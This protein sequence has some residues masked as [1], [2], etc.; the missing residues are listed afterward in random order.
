VEHLLSRLESS[1]RP[2]RILVSSA[3]EA[4]TFERLAGRSTAIAE[5]IGALGLKTL[6]LHMDNR[7]DWVV[8]D[9]A[10][11]QAAVCLVPLPTF[12]S[13]GQIR[14]VLDSVPVDAVFTEQPE[15]LATLCAGRIR[16]G[17]ELAIGG[18]ELLLLDPASQGAALPPGSGKVTFTSGSTGRPKGVCLS[19]AQL[20]TQAAALS[21][22]AG[23]AAPRHL[24]LLPL[25]TLLENIAGIYAPLLAGGEVVVPTLDEVG[26]TGSSSLNPRVLLALLSREQP[27]SIILT[28]QLLQLLV[29]AAQ[30]GWVPPPSL[31]FVAVGGAKVSPDL[32]DAARAAGI[33]AFEGYGLSE[34]ASVVSLNVPGSE[35][36]GS[37]GRPLAHLG[38]AIDAGEIVVRG[39]AMLG[40][41]GEPASWHPN[42][43]RTGDLGYFD[44]DGYLFINGRSKNLLISSYGRNISP[45]WVES[46][47]QAEPSLA[48]CVVFGDAR[49]YCVALL[50][51]RDPSASDAA[52]QRAVDRC[53]ARLPDYARVRH[54]HRLAQP[55][56]TAGGLLTENGRPK[57][58][59][60][61]SR[62]DAVIESLYEPPTNAR[63]A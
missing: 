21:R 13:S 41:A 5:L 59:A 4:L 34:C 35:R 28:P 30:S 60:I 46:E 49:P 26:F 27:N 8:V 22:A 31:S 61:L 52:I 56:A 47:L 25:S 53:N 40:Y 6:A 7:A 43:I 12:F 1:S 58:Q 16:P 29:A 57:R 50:S 44:D 19:N 18:C 23:L 39:N 62:F 11:Q 20:L 33:P 63:I 55:L 15:Y 14:H 10:C 51:P 3:H 38:V 37:C 54:W 48:E 17:P 2:D 36:P 32:L 24:C 45:E 9:L 42:V